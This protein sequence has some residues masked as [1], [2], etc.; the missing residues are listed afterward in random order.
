MTTDYD[1]FRRNVI[2]AVEKKLGKYPWFRGVCTEGIKYF[3]PD[4][5]GGAVCF[6][7]E[8]TRYYDETN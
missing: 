2:R 4:D 8:N 1:L 5:F 6:S 3:Y 7:A